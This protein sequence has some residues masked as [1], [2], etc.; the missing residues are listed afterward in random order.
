MEENRCKTKGQ[1]SC[2]LTKERKTCS[3]FDKNIE[4]NFSHKDAKKKNVEQ[5]DKSHVGPRK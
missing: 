3:S 5:K 1:K 4:K 2:G